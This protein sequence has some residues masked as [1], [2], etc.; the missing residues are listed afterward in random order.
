M[1]MGPSAPRADTHLDLRTASTCLK[2]CASEFGDDALTW[3][4]LPQLA[5]LVARFE[6]LRRRS[7]TTPARN[8]VRGLTSRAGPSVV[9]VDG[10][11]F[12]TTSVQHR[13]VLDPVVS[14]FARTAGADPRIV[15]LPGLSVIEV[16]R[17]WSRASR[18]NRV[19]E[20][21]A[22][23]QGVSLPAQVRDVIFQSA[24]LLGRANR[25]ATLDSYPQV[26]VVGTQHNS[27]ERAVLQAAIMSGRATVYVPHAPVA[28]NPMYEDLPT[29]WAIVR[30]PGR[31]GLVSRSRCRTGDA[32]WRRSFHR[33]EGAGQHSAVGAGCLCS[34][35]RPDHSATR[36]AAHLFGGAAERHLLSSSEVRGGDRRGRGISHLVAP[37]HG[38]KHVRRTQNRW[39][40]CPHPKRKWRRIGGIA[41]RTAV[42]DLRSPGS[43]AHYP[44]L[45]SPLI[46][47]AHNGEELAAI[48]SE[49][50]GGRHRDRERRDYAM[51]WS[52]FGGAEAASVIAEQIGVL[53]RS[54]IPQTLVLDGWA[55]P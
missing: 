9:G 49:V 3:I 15:Q 54:E 25:A 28:D 26:L 16:A 47:V 2:E 18:L 38:R 8:L 17:A 43:S 48:L 41:S 23:S 40:D 21:W 53:R 51:T 44:Y 45:R 29:H 52:A 55:A 1:S 27:A 19:L 20:K 33:V 46:E 13:R 5:M 31:G 36:R 32:G 7:P 6:S 34:G 50:E 11:G 4:V 10:V 42:I 14:E 35:R 30:G 37:W 39:S 24:V 22:L 12:V